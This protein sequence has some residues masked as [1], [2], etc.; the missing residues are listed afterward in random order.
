MNVASVIVCIVTI[1]I[2]LFS[3]DKVFHLALE[4]ATLALYVNLGSMFNAEVFESFTREYFVLLVMIVVSIFAKPILT[5]KKL[6][7]A[8]LGLL[9]CIFI[10][11]LSILLIPTNATVAP[12]SITYDEVVMS[13]KSLSNPFLGS[14][15]F[16]AFLLL[17]IF[18]VSAVIVSG[19]FRKENYVYRAINYFELTAIIFFF[20]IV[21]ESVLINILEISD[22]RLFIIRLL[23]ASE[24]T[25]VYDFSTVRFLGV[26]SSFLFYSEPSFVCMPL[27]VFYLINYQKGK[28]SNKKMGLFILSFAVAILSGSTNCMIIALFGVF[29]LIKILFFNKGISDSKR[30][31]KIVFLFF[32]AAVSFL[33]IASKT[34]IYDQ[35]IDRIWSKLSAYLTME[36]VAD[37]SSVSGYIRR[38]GNSICYSVLKTNPLFGVGLG[39]TRGYGFIPSMLATMG[40]IG[41]VAFCN[42]YYR[43]FSLKIRKA[44]VL[45]LI[46][47]IGVLTGIMGV[48]HMYSFVM[49]PILLCFNRCVDLNKQN[50]IGLFNVSYKNRKNYRGLHK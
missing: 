40:M 50:Q 35:L 4:A 11:Y 14:S 39:T 19:L 25:K 26:Q 28:P 21:L 41:S 1:H 36:K 44:N 33:F 43:A 24:Q 34:K 17:V 30:I 46:F 22:W 23:G 27:L 37:G 31:F 10:S 47:L 45:E 48:W 9:G 6:I 29:T 49:L 2:V 7:Y 13:G 8:M 20:L 15:N 32:V 12:M 42:F 38:F 5:Y 16:G 3:N 18:L